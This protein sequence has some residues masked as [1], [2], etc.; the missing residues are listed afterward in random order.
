M[1]RDLEIDEW[2][3][4]KEPPV[5]YGGDSNINGLTY[6]IIGLCFE[7]YNNL[8]RGF[9]EV[10]YK[11]ALTHEFKVNDIGFEREKKFEIKYKDTILPHHYFSDFVV[12]GEVVLEIKAQ[13][14]IIEEHTKQVLNY[15]AISGCK[16]GLLINFGED[17]LKY[18]RLILSK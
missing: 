9:L 4:I 13:K 2:V 7:V 15:L 10:V 18:K 8:G 3:E 11:D 6:E 5:Q 16:I 17:S 1:Y 12:E 14:G